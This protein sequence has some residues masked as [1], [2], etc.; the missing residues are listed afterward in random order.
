MK[1]NAYMASDDRHPSI[2]PSTRKRWRVFKKPG[3]P[4][5]SKRKLNE[6]TQHIRPWEIQN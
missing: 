2:Y 5:V 4:E 1:L 6:L 3:R